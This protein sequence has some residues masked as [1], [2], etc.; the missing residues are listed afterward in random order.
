MECETASMHRKIRSA[1]PSPRA[2]PH[3]LRV[4]TLTSQAYFLQTSMDRRCMHSF[5]PMMTARII[6]LACF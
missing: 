4:K 1:L 2:V 6:P 3:V 5:P